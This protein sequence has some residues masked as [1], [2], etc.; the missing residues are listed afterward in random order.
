MIDKQHFLLAW[1]GL[2]DPEL[3]TC[4]ALLVYATYNV[5]NTARK[6]SPMGMG[7]AVEALKQG[8]RNGVRGHSGSMKILDNRYGVKKARR[9]SGS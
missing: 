8:C 7:D 6:E 2:K 9:S 5:T 3:L 1:S 4:L